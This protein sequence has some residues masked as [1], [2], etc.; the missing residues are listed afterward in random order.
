MTCASPSVSTERVIGSFI[1]NAPGSSLCI[2]FNAFNGPSVLTVPWGLGKLCGLELHSKPT[3]RGLVSA[4]LSQQLGRLFDLRNRRRG[5]IA[6]LSLVRFD[7]MQKRCSRLGAWSSVHVVCNAAVGYAESL[8][9]LSD[10][11]IL[12]D[13]SP[14]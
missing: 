9:Q 13:T 4:R 8:L 12:L 3:L 1:S 10:T 6:L 7:M 14:I 2:L 11:S 5:I